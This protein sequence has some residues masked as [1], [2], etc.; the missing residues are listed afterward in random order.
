MSLTPGTRL[1]VYEVTSLIGEGGMG[2]VYRAT[3]TKL[4]RQVAIKILPPSLAADHDR[5]TRFQREA[6]V[7]ASLNHPN[8]AHIHGLEEGGGGT[9]LVMELVE[10]EDL[11]QRLARGA[12]PLDEAL[13]IARQIAEALEAAHEQGIIHRDL[14]PANIKVRADGTVKVL[15]FGLA[16]A[17]D[18]A[19]ASSP[20]VMNSPTM[21]AH[22]TQ[23]GMIVGTAPY[24]SPEQARGKAVDRRADI[25]AFGAVLF[26]MVTGKRA[27]PGEDV[28]DTL[29]AV[30]RAEPEWS[31]VPREMSPT[32]LLYLRR[33]LHKDPKQRIGDIHDVRLALDGALDVAAQAP[34]AGAPTPA[35]RAR[36]PWIVA[37]VSIILAAA[38]A[39]PAVR[40]LGEAPPLTPLEIRTDIAT[41]GGGTFALSPD[42]RQLAFVASS[43]GTIRLWLRLLSD[44]AAR[45]LAGTDGA[46]NPFW[47]PD[48]RSIAFFAGTELRRLDLAGGAP[49]TVA[50]AGRFI[51]GTWGADGVILYS[52]NTGPSVNEL[53]RVSVAGG[54]PTLV[55]PLGPDMGYYAPWFLPDGKRFLFTASGKPDAAG[56]YLGTL[57]GSPPT[58]LTPDVGTG[59]YLPGAWRDGGWLVWLRTDDRLVAQ[60]LDSGEAGIDRRSRVG[61]RRRGVRLRIVGRADGLPERGRQLPTAAG[62][63]R[64]PRHPT[65]DRGRTRQPVRLRPFAGWKE[66]GPYRWDR[67]HIGGDRWGHHIRHRHLDIGGDAGSQNTI[68]VRAGGG[69]EPDLVS[70]WPLAGLRIFSIRASQSLQESGGRSGRVRGVAVCRRAPQATP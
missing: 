31:L 18:P 38:L 43:G 19:G 7:L 41:P 25:W 1:G 27:F 33:C 36:L 57:D 35:S 49:Q 63:V 20:D 9:S 28:T 48:S 39:I 37:A 22:G 59:L 11:S 69:P 68:H 14:K 13:P 2:Q 67:R 62:V 3:D 12:I 45:P 21:I 4:K 52:E 47:S 6:E 60:R 26:E 46:L 29:A 54:A 42:G 10:G 61:G 64:R 40:H 56:I 15:D 24:M 51:L 8:I 66:R 58:R 30:V 55:T 50:A 32:L 65:R 70:R 17:M 5:L 16:K 23:I 44:A 34:T 53:K